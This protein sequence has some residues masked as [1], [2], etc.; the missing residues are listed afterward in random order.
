MTGRVALVSGTASG[1]GRAMA[2]GLAEAGAD[3]MLADRNT[4]GNEATAEQIAGLGRR[5]IPVTCDLSDP[6]QIRAMYARLDREYG[7]ID[8]LGNVAGDGCQVAPEEL[9]LQQLQDVLPTL[10]VPHPRGV[11]VR[12]LVHQDQFRFPRQRRIQVEVLE[13]PSPMLYLPPR[14]DFEPLEQHIG[15]A[16]AM[17]LD[18]PGQHVGPGSLLRPSRLQHG[19]GLPHARGRP[20]ENL[21]AAE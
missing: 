12:Q 7:R 14:Q 16:P 17:G 18:V 9:S 6:D 10:G 1:L 5:A 4:A 13:R 20:E 3:L 15:F 19:V 11:R 21:Q 8:V 2:L